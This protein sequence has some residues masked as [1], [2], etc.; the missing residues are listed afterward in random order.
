MRS[1]PIP[2]LR[3]SRPAQSRAF[4]AALLFAAASLGACS[5]EKDAAISADSAAASGTRSEA[6]AP[7]TAPHGGMLVAVGKGVAQLEFNVDTTKG[8]VVVHVLDGAAKEPLRLTQ[9]RI[10]LKMLDLVEG[11][12]DVSTILAAR[13]NASTNETLD[14]TS[15]FVGFVP[16][17]LGHGRF[18]AR[19]QRIEVGGQVFTD[20]PVSFPPGANA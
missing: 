4:V 15:V 14:N 20:I 3:Q 18:R 8:V 7:L 10:D 5:G 12:G 19:I 17:L 6:T 2:F 16:Q 9:G 11:G 1:T 13:A